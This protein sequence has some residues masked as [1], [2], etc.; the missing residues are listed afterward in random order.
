[1]YPGL[2]KVFVRDIQNRL[3][4]LLQVV[5]GRQ[6]KVGTVPLKSRLEFRPIA[7]GFV[8]GQHHLAHSGDLGV[9][10]A[11]KAIVAKDDLSQ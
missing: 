9:S 10:L 1:M 8:C 5:K 6:S 7:A 3:E 2:E 4:L 11:E